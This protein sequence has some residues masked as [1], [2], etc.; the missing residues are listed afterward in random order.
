MGQSKI[1]YDLKFWIISTEN[2]G[3]Q[4]GQNTLRVEINQFCDD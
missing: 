1:R 4:K 2:C 3:K